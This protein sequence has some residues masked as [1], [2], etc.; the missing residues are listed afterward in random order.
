VAVS[1]LRDY[2]GNL[3]TPFASSFTTRAVAV[4]DTTAPAIVSITPLDGAS[5]VG[6]TTPVSLTVSEPIVASTVGAASVP[7][8]AAVAGQFIQLAGSYAVDASG[9]TITFTPVA[10]YPGSTLIW[11]YINSSGT[12]TD[13]A[14]NLLPFTARS[15]TTANA[16]DAAPPAVI[17]VTPAAGTLDVGLNSSVTV[18]FSESLAPATVSNTTFEL[19]AGTQRLFPSVQRSLDNRSVTLTTSL[20]ASALVTLVITSG[21]TDI[22]GN[23]L[24]DFTSTFTTAGARETTPGRVT[25][26]QPVSGASRV[27]PSTPMITLVLSEPVAPATVPGALYVAQN[28]VLVAGS[29]AVTSAGTTIEFVPAA[30]WAPGAL[31]QVFLEG[32]QDLAGN[33]IAVHQGSFTIAPDPATTIATLVRATPSGANVPLNPIVEL[34]FTETLNPATVTDSSVRLLLQGAQPVAITLSVRDGRVIRIAPQSALT[35]S[36]TFYVQVNGVTDSQGVPVAGQFFAAFTTGSTADTTPPTVTAV[37]PPGGSSDVGTNAM[38]RIR[39][40]EPINPITVNAT[41]VAVTAPG[42]VAVPASISFNPTDTEAAITPLQPLPANAAIAVAI[43]G[44]QDRAGHSVAPLQSTFQTGPDVDT[45]V[46]QALVVNPYYGATA[47]PVNTVVTVEYDELL[48]PASLRPDTVQLVD[49]V[50][51]LV[52]PTTPS[53]DADGRTLLVAP[54]SPLAPAR[55]HYVYINYASN[56]R[57]LAGNVATGVFIAF[58][59]ANTSDATP[60]AVVLTSPADG[61]AAVPINSTIE[62]RFDEPINPSTMDGVTLMRGGT[63]VA[64]TRTIA[65]G[66][67]T[68][69][70]V[71]ATLLMPNTAYAIAISAVQDVAGNVV[72]GVVEA[73]F[74]TGPGADFTPPTVSLMQPSAGATG[75]PV[76][77]TP[78]V[79]FSEAINALTAVGTISLRV[80][81][82]GVAVPVTYGFSADGRTVTLVPAAPLAAATQYTLA[83]GFGV[84]DLAGNFGN[85]QPSRTF[86]TQ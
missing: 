77:V 60:P 8:Y 65:D 29:T 35:A 21:V 12:I 81:N 28:G 51:G 9:T 63:P 48:D 31:V 61:L 2:T 17:S 69:R 41:T 11:T 37:A 82:T 68:V 64:A 18:T 72:A 75:V 73:A 58:T 22:A 32:A 36:Q 83:V 38:I 79:T 85:A 44:V 33:A 76:S 52:V 78:Q 86:T 56:L 23:A 70:I 6:V 40:S 66:N 46:P 43:A 19:F 20:P 67:R 34:E 49:G 14:G 47:V 25:T 27:P 57:D 59:T 4:A 5:G 10:P 3:L 84:R 54:L 13:Y 80:T 24:A 55:G 26:Q 15:F 53:L 71:P 1:G 7:V 16:A 74:T 62:V 30:P 45:V 39:F 50:T 42:F